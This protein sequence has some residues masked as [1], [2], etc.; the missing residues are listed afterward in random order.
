M[1]EKRYRTVKSAG[2]LNLVAGIISITVGVTM[3]VL[4]IISGARLL[5]S[6]SNHLF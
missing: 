5:A 3:G 4:L 2:A 6:K 1:D